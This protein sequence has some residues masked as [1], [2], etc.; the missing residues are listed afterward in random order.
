VAL[1]DPHNSRKRAQVCAVSHPQEAQPLITPNKVP[2]ITRTTPLDTL[3]DGTAQPVLDIEDNLFLHKTPTHDTCARTPT[4]GVPNQS[5]AT[6][7]AQR[8]E[9]LLT[10]QFSGHVAGQRTSILL[11][12]GA[13]HNFLNAAACTNWQLPINRHDGVVHAADGVDLP[14]RGTCKVPVDI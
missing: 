4:M 2:R 9:Q 3:I 12:S 5:L 6:I 8:T 10:M 7:L 11:D 14:I 1:P 13:T